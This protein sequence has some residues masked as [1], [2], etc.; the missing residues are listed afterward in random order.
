MHLLYF[1]TIVVILAQKYIFFHF[2]FFIKNVK[3]NKDLLFQMYYLIY[4]TLLFIYLFIYL[5]T[6]THRDP[7]AK[8]VE[9]FSTKTSTH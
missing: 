1:D 5:H 2:N 4:L 3:N 8:P 6:Q 9:N 7:K